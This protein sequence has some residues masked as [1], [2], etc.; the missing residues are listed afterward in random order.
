[1]EIAKKRHLSEIALGFFLLSHPGPVL[2]HI[3]SVT[4]FTLLAAWPK[5][6]WVTIVLV[7]AAHTAMQLSIAFLNDYCDRHLDT[8]SKR[9]KPI[10][11]GLIRPHEALI[12]SVLMIVL[13]LGLLSPL[14]RWAFVISFVYLILLQG[15]NLGLKSTPLSGIVFA[16][17][18][19]LIPLYAFAGLGR[20]L[21]FLIWLVPLGFLLGV[22][23]NV[24]NSVP[25][26]EADE[27]NGARTL[28]VVLG[29]KRSLFICPLMIVFAA[30]LI[31]VLTLWRIV[32][33]QPW[34]ILTTFVITCLAVGTMF[35]FFS[36]IKPIRMPKF[37]FYLVALTCIVLAGG[38]FIGVSV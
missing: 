31:G 17:G 18:M 4:I 30:I 25:D 32:P 2:L 8:L 36:P 14:N 11:R 33:A 3:I 22:T 12:A 37:Y 23:I 16:L 9:S 19:P 6:V 28:A 27:A 24:A 5:F 10:V 15:Y 13:M 29:L 38:W 21:P 7:I 20:T 1:M 35:L 26:I 34:I